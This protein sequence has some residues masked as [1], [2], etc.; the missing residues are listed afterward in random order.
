MIQTVRKNYEGFT[1][2]EVLRAKRARELQTM[3][4]APSEK[5]YYGVVSNNML[6][7]CPVHRNDVTNARKIYGPDITGIR[8]KTVRKKPVP[9]VES[10]VAVPRDFV[11]N[12]KYITLAA[13]VF[14][15]DGIPILLTLS[16]KIKFITTEY[17]PV[18]TAKQLSKSIKKVLRVYQRAGFTVRTVLMDG[19]FEKVKEELPSIVSNTTA[20]K[21]HVAEAERSIRVVKERSRGIR[22]LLP[23]THIPRR[24]KI[25]LIYNITLWL[26]AFPVKS[27][28]SA[29]F[30]PREIIVRY[31]LDFKK[32][33]RGLFGAYVEARDEPEPSNSQIP[34]THECTTRTDRR[35]VLRVQAI[36][37]SHQEGPQENALHRHPYS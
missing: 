32:H 37:P 35:T 31:K 7:N 30:S 13:D 1:K 17:T 5:D 22:A 20:A 18:R 33:C 2:K 26:N 10:Y 4:G 16:R 34:R 28:M 6:D 9:V 11:L 27:G 19:E 12:N 36:L 29:K 25:E 8:G 3:V 14:F 23:Y 21:E 24:V 15:V